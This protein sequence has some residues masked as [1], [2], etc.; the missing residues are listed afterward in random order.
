MSFFSEISKLLKDV[1]YFEVFNNMV[2]DIIIKV[3][4]IACQPLTL[5]IHFDHRLYKAL[6]LSW[7][8]SYQTLN[9]CAVVLSICFCTLSRS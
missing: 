3:K 1:E 2:I 7:M 9:D 4:L 8:Y 5:N 6:H